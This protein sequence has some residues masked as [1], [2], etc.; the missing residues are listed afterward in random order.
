MEI[1]NIGFKLSQRHLE[2]NYDPFSTV[3]IDFYIVR[4]SLM[5]ILD[6]R[7]V[8]WSWQNPVFPGIS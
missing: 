7:Y 8:D 4:I 1:V 2:I 6:L 5:I 3:E